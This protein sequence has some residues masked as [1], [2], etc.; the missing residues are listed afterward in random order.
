MASC[1]VIGRGYNYATAFELALKLKELTHTVVE[2]NSSADFQH[3]PMALIEPG[4]PVIVVAPSGKMLAEI[5]GFMQI[6]HEREIVT[7]CHDPP[8]YRRHPVERPCW[9]P[10]TLG[11]D[12][13]CLLNRMTDQVALLYGIIRMPL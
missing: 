12:L 9:R 8:S 7:V 6:L 10:D 5:Q 11:Y 4:F 13:K 2:P 1:I 3:G